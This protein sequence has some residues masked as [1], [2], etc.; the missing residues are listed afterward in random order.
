MV[1]PS[2]S[3]DRRSNRPAAALGHIGCTLGAAGS[4]DTARRLA[5]EP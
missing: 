5:E 3:P 1:Q 2:S 4:T